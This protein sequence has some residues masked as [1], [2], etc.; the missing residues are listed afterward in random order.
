MVTSLQL[1]KEQWDSIRE[2]AGMKLVKGGS[3]VSHLG[4]PD[5]NTC[6]DYHEKCPFWADVV[7]EAVADFSATSVS[8]S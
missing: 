1:Y 4:K 2:Q 5:G 8:Q 7:S 6:M 3:F